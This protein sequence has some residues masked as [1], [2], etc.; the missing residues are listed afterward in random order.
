VIIAWQVLE[1]RLH[2]IMES[3]GDAGGNLSAGLIALGTASPGQVIVAYA[4]RALSAGLWLLA[5]CG[6]LTRRQW[7]RRPG[8]PLVMIGISPLAFLAGGSYGGEIIFRIYLFAL[9][10]TAMLAAALFLPARRAWVRTIALPVV[11]LLMVTG[12]FFGN[13]GKEQANY[14]TREE[15]QLVRELHR[16]APNRS[17]I[18]APTFFL[19]AAYDYYERYDHVWLDELP[20]SR[21]AVRN[22][23]DHVPTLSQFVKEPRSSLIG[24]MEN[25]Q[26]GAKG[27]LV[28]N[29]A[30]RAATETAGIF[31][32][33]TIDRLHREI[34][35][36][37]RFK[38]VL[39]NAGG[40]VFELVPPKRKANGGGGE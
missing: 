12:F 24:L 38:V 15:V 31:P 6:A 28:L 3:L 37:D 33:G 4:D 9:P 32:K 7:L 26:P 39:S 21:T 5:L 14:F 19:P 23:P 8:L 30:Q 40:A 34:S 35:T 27:Y 10:L 18:V 13:Y 22:L 36:S 29:R 16:M 11:L 2:S 25:L 20:P 1:A 17:L